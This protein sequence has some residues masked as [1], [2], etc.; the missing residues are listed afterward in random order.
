MKKLLLIAPEDELSVDFSGL[1]SQDF[2]V[3]RAIDEDSGFKILDDRLDEIAAVLIDLDLTRNTG[4]RI[5]NLMDRNMIFASV[6]VIAITDHTPVE[7]DLE[8]LKNGYSELLSPPG[9][10]EIVIT[11]I[12]Q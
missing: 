7:E 6:P 12:I 11:R 3:I 4:Y 2:E 1:L 9:I 5:K 10:R 8:C